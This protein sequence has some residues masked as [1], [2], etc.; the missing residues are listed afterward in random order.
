MLREA[1]KNFLIDLL[2]FLTIAAII[3]IVFK[4]LAGY[5]LPFVIGL[6]I[7]ALVQTPTRFVS[8]HTK[9][10]KGICSVILVLLSFGIVASLI[11]LLVY[12]VYTIGAK[13]ASTLPFIINEISETWDI[14]ST[15]VN[16]IMVDMPGFAQNSAQD[17]IS[18]LIVDAG[19]AVTGWLPG[20]AANI[21][22]S[23]PEYIVITIVTIVSSCYFAK[24]FDI[25]KSLFKKILKPN[26][27]ELISE[28]REIAFKNVFKLIKSYGFIML[29]TFVELSI[30]LLIIGV[31]NALLLA[32][33][34]AIVDV[35]PVLG[36]GTVLIPWGIIAL[37]Q[38]NYLLGIGVLLLYVVILIV[39][40]IIEPKI[41]GDQVGMHPL[42]TL[43]TIFVGLR[44]LGVLGMFA[45]PVVAII[46]IQLYR[47][48]KL[49]F[50]FI[51]NES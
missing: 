34:I 23:T 11:S 6:I 13:I 30:G 25:I 4:F 1:K 51:K 5:L 40:N 47:N 39:R 26:H 35:L 43:L 20:F 38:G 22:L 10:P 8:K 32:L 15:V 36:C 12:F 28:V 9:V 41:I 48:G 7:A 49:K 24:D 42:V 33:I 31:D 17:L 46:L 44:F 3:Y 14:I 37:I 19:K 21:A 2:F 16:D 18:G 27:V 29:I 50:S 45:L